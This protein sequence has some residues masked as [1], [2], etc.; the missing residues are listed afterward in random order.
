MGGWRRRGPLAVLSVVMARPRKGSRT[1]KRK[2]SFHRGRKET[3][4]W[5]KADRMFRRL[6][7][8]RA[9]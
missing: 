3:R 6:E 4:R 7:K 8:R 9:S 5:E 2:R 1:N